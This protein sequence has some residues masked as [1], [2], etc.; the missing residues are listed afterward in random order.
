VSVYRAVARTPQAGLWEYTIVNNTNVRRPCFL[1][2]GSQSWPITLDRANTGLSYLSAWLRYPGASPVLRVGN[3][4]VPLQ[5]GA[6]YE[7]YTMWN[8]QAGIRKIG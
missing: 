5:D 7:L 2:I 6:A 8:G 4:S 3:T 1:Q